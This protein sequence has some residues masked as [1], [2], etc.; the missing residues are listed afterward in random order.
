MRETRVQSEVGALRLSSVLT[1]VFASGAV[2]IALFSD[3]ETMT[4]EAMSG[5]VDVLISFLCI[6]VIRKVHQP[7]DRH[8]HFGYAKY[9]PLMTTVEGL[10]VTA[11]CASAIGYAVRD[12]LHPDP[13]ENPRLVIVYSL[14]SFL[15]SIVFGAWMKRVGHRTTSQLVQA[16]AELWIVEG[17]LALGVFAAFGISEIMKRWGSIQASSYVD[18]SVCII[19][20]VILLRKPYDILKESLADLVDANPYAETVNAVEESARA[21]VERFQLKGLEWV[22]VRKAGRRVFVLVSFF[23][24]PD[25]LAQEMDNVRQAMTEE[26]ARL[27]PDLDVGILFKTG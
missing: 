19:L 7:A 16:E 1:I 12:L 23:L 13:V 24:D 6:F 14:I 3:S 5:V 17:W 27:N 26:L 22:R 11:V 18:P 20:S 4:L 15:V 2:V 10:L 25:R 21:C 9:E 8:Y